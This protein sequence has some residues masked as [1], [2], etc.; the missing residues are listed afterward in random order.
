MI[1]AMLGVLRI[2]RTFAQSQFVTIPNLFPH[3]AVGRGHFAGPELVPRLGRPSITCP[4]WASFVFLLPPRM[5][6]NAPFTQTGWAG[7]SAEQPLLLPFFH[8]F[9]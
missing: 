5:V 2:G 9:T 1:W 6:Q 4:W 3:N 7:E 8:F